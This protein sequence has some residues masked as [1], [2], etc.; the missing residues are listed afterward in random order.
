M[1]FKV[2][3]TRLQVARSMCLALDQNKSRDLLDKRKSREELA[4]ISQ[5]LP[6]AHTTAHLWR[7]PLA[8]SD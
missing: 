8:I 1:P 2:L 7:I 4:A 3:E 5:Y 6:Q